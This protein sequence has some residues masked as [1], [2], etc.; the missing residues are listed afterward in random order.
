MKSILKIVPISLFFAGVFMSLS[1]QRIIN[2]AAPVTVNMPGAF[3]ATGRYPSVELEISRSGKLAIATTPNEAKVWKL[4]GG[5]LLYRFQKPASADERGEVITY[6]SISLYLTSDEK[7]LYPH[8]KTEVANMETGEL[9]ADG[10]LRDSILSGNY[11]M[12]R[13][14]YRNLTPFPPALWT[15][16]FTAGSSPL[17]A[18]RDYTPP[19]FDERI[20]PIIYEADPFEKDVLQIIYRQEYCGSKDWIKNTLKK[21]VSEFRARLKKNNNSTYYDYHW[22]SYNVATGKVLYFGRLMDS[23]STRIPGAFAG[24]Q[25]ASISPFGDVAVAECFGHYRIF[26]PNG[27]MLW[28]TPDNTYTFDHFDALGNIVMRRSAVGNGNAAISVHAPASGEAIATY[29]IPGNGLKNTIGLVEQWGMISNIS[30]NEDGIF[31][32]SFHNPETGALMISLTDD[33]AARAFAAKYHKDA[34]AF[35]AAYAARQEAARIYWAEESRRQAAAYAAAY[36]KQVEQAKAYTGNT[37]I[38][39]ACKR[40]SGTG[41]EMS[42]GFMYNKTTR[43]YSSGAGSNSTNYRVTSTPVYSNYETRAICSA[44]GGKGKS[45]R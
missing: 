38:T 43:E 24:V 28:R 7:Y 29:N 30:K 21:D 23:A 3:A 12:W 8:T 34:A 41:W 9:L 19:G 37:K 45:G 42:K 16:L 4:P 2:G 27:R 44:C 5:E 40:C 36:A 15:K 18:K 14:N 20:G 11:E 39:N 32:I 10:A 13:G 35:V 17:S 25:S 22:A 31:A 33:A 6:G 1:A 26:A